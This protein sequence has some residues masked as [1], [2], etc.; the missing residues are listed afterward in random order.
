[1]T[2]FIHLSFVLLVLFSFIGRIVLSEVRP[3]LL[4]RKAIKIAPHVIDTLLLVSGIVLVFDGG[5]LSGDFSWII[6]KII[7]LFAY[8]GFGM[9]AMKQQGK[10]RWLAFAGAIA[11]FAYIGSVAVAKHAWFF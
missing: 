6:A 11:C 2:K 4:K 5:W 1:M 7:A 8:I 10:I 9:I 3:E